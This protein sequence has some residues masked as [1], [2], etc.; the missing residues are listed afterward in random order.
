MSPDKRAL[1]DVSIDGWSHLKTYGIDALTGE[2]C[3][4]SNR[5][6]CDLNE[7]GKDHIISFLGLDEMGAASPNVFAPNW[8]SGRDMA[9]P[10]VASIMLPKSCFVELT[11]HI[12]QRKGFEEYLVDTQHRI[13]YATMR[14]VSDA[15]RYLVANA[16]GHYRKGWFPQSTSNEHQMSGR[17]QG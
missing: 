12:L 14:P 13:V 9:T 4:L 3:A 11:M 15:W 8:N 1:M 5:L 10:A 6:L 7:E 17:S 16:S 2:A